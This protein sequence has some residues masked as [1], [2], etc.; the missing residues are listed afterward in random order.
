MT[1]QEESLNT[2]GARTDQQAPRVSPRLMVFAL[3]GV[4]TALLVAAMSLVPVP[5][6]IFSPGPATNV[7]G[8]VNGRPII[9]VVK[10]PTY[11]LK[12]AGTLDMTTVEVYGGPGSAVTFLDALRGWVSGDQTVVPRESVF[13]PG[14]TADDVA[15]ENAQLMSQSQRDA[16]AVG[17]REAGLTV[18][19][20]ILVEAVKPDAPAAAAIR[21]GDQVVEVGGQKVKDVSAIRTAVRAVPSD[22]PVEV[23]VMR[24]SK[25]VQVRT[26]TLMVDGQPALGVTLRTEY[27]FP[28]EVRFATRDVGGPSAGM[29]FA[30]GIYDLL[31]PGD[32]TGGKRVAGTGTVAP[33]GKVGPIGGIT[34]KMIGA[35][36]NGAG[37][38]LAPEA[39]CDEVLVG[40]PDDLEVVAVKTVPQ[41]RDAVEDIAAGR[42]D[43]L[44]R[45]Q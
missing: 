12:N 4:L 33:D 39:N 41:A 16:T 22:S 26:R 44:P 21:A 38:F 11:R 25:E 1:D 7:L 37:W 45:C 43:S 13:P 14:E 27:D 3:N 40:Q 8:L 29:M 30:L 23:S 6:A 31:T 18:S 35:Q 15:S 17:L 42:V 5:Y 19:E 28:V 36:A 9:D 34:Q 10:N 20:K 32:F 24:G 2:E